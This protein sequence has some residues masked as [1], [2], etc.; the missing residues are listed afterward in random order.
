M[1]LLLAEDEHSLSRAIIKILEKNNYTALDEEKL[2]EIL[3][4]IILSIASLQKQK[5][6]VWKP[7]E[8][9]LPN[10]RS[11]RLFNFLEK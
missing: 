6:T 11:Q 10:I 8:K 4:K 3:Q 1:K 2:Y 7:E 9:Y 5:L